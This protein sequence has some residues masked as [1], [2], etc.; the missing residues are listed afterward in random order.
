MVNTHRE[1]GPVKD[2]KQERYLSYYGIRQSI[3]DGA[4]LEVH[5]LC[6]PVPLETEETQLSVGF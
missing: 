6:R 4:T 3:K 1:F 2:G 5:Y